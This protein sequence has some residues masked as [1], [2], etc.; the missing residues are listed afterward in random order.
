V[1]REEEERESE[2]QGGELFSHFPPLTLSPHS[3]LSSFPSLLTVSLSSHSVSLFSLLSL[4]V[5]LSLLSLTLFS[6]PL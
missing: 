6:P 3:S 5:S 1:R 4:C 2:R